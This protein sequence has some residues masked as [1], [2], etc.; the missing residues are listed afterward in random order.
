M[1]CASGDSRVTVYRLKS[2]RVRVRCRQPV[3]VTRSMKAEVSQS[4][5]PIECCLQRLKGERSPEPRA[6]RDQRVGRTRGVSGCSRE[7][8]T[9]AVPSTARLVA[10]RPPLMGLQPTRVL[11]EGFFCSDN[12]DRSFIFLLLCPSE[13]RVSTQLRR[14][15]KHAGRWE[16]RRS[17]RWGGGVPPNAMQYVPNR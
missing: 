3:R 11:S 1:S 15:G 5:W 8:R 10:R 16:T 2:L 6:R 12:V 17:P 4:W 13:S 7:E 9:P 14:V